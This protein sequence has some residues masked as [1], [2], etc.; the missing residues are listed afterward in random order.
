MRVSVLSYLS[1][2]FSLSDEQAMLRVQKEN[3]PR[4]FSL[5][6][7][8]WQDQIQGLCAR[9][10][11][12]VHRGED[13]AQEV[14]MRVFA[15][16]NDYRGEASFATYLRRIALNA[17]YDE[18]RR[19]KRRNEDSLKHN[20]PENTLGAASVTP[21]L[22]PEMVAAKQERAELVR[23]ALFRLADQYREV[24]ILRHYEGLRFREI[25][26][27]VQSRMAEA[28]TQLGRFL[29]PILKEETH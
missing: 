3:D 19:L 18:Q 27:T 5:L 21:M 24:V 22:S 7:R 16:R 17:C 28:L 6:V 23:K 15:H 8:R 26:G 25:Q 11:G 29:K 10:M 20:N 1:D 14:F 2:L 9:L 13:L 4:A 12:D